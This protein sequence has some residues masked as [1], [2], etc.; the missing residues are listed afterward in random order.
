M[1]GPRK[2][3]T[4]CRGGAPAW[5][6]VWRDRAECIWY[7]EACVEH[8]QN[9]RKD[10]SDR[11]QYGV[12]IRLHTSRSTTSLFANQAECCNDRLRPHHKWGTEVAVVQKPSADPLVTFGV[13]LPLAVRLTP[14]EQT[15]PLVANIAI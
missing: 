2:L 14:A 15:A 1:I 4:T 13:L 11:H 10:Q 6:G 12:S 7:V 8:A 5:K 3:Q 9:D